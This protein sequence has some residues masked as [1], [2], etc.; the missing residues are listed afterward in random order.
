MYV[1]SEAILYICFA[2]LV[3]GSLINLIPESKKPSIII[4]N[5]VILGAIV[6]IVIFSF[7]QII[8]LIIFF[9][10][11]LGYEIG[12]ITYKVITDYKIGNAWVLTLLIAIALLYLHKLG[13]T[14]SIYRFKWK[15]IFALSILLVGCFGWASHSATVY[16]WQGFMAQSIHFLAVTIWVGVMMVVGWF[17]KGSQNW[18]AF[19]RWFSPLSISCVVVAISAG[20]FLMSKLTPQYIDSWMTSYGQALLVKHLLI[21]PLL[22][23]AWINGFLLKRWVIKNPT[24]SPLPW[25]R[26][27]S[28]VVLMVLVATA[29]MAKQSPPHDDLQ[30]FLKEE[31]PSSLFVWLTGF[32][33]GQGNSILLGYNPV[34]LVFGGVSA[35]ALL[36]GMPLSWKRKSYGLAVGAGL[37]FVGTG[38]LSL[39]FAVR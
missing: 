39:M 29:Y 13:D 6:G 7:V 27:E 14:S 34:S 2:L 23:I 21:I 12:F 16:E 1:V 30:A 17:A 10:V 36:L 20:F 24:Y 11:N 35:L 18:P 9:R 15:G 22:G 8:Q 25:L 3:G 5:H 28:I 31:A 33:H 19:L 38:Y 37:L 4:H 32:D 26:A